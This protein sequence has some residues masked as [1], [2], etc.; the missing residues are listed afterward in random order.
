[1][2]IAIQAGRRLHFWLVCMACSIRHFSFALLILV[3]FETLSAN[4]TVYYL[5]SR[6]GSDDSNGTSPGTA[7]K[8]LARVNAQMFHAGDEIRFKAGTRYVGQLKPQGSG[9]IEDGKV[10]PIVIDAY[11]KGPRPRIDGEGEVLDTLLLRNV[12]FWD[13]RGLEITNLGKHR[14][15]W[16][17]GVH[18]V[19]D[20]F[21]TMW[22][23]HLQDLFVHDVNGDLRKEREGC[24]IFFES[25]GGNHSH[26]DNLLIENCHLL[27]TDRNG[28]CQRTT[29]RSRSLHVVIHGNLLEDIGGDGIKVWGSDGPLVEHNV[30]RGGRMRCKD[31]AAGIWPYD[32]DNAVIQ[33]NEVSGMKGTKDGEGFDS[34]YRCRHSLFQYNYS[35][36]NDGGFML[37]CTPGNSY[38][39]DTVIRYNISQNDGINTARVFHFGGGAKD[40][41][42]YNN[43]VYVGRKQDLPLLLFTEWNRGNASNTKFYN[44]IF[45]VDGHVTCDFG[46][47]TNNVFDRNVFYCPNGGIPPQAHAISNRPPLINPGSGGNGFASLNGYRLRDDAGFPLGRIVPN[48]GG[49][50]FFGNP[51]PQD[52]EP[53]I[54]AVQLVP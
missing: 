34:D 42:V 33:F 30:L 6:T 1:M 18:I 52:S 40:T 23:I 28:I 54:G 44:N 53:S 49:R 5:D 27:R 32:C 3:A 51:V 20:N 50:D 35:H 21:G 8:S 4:A 7:W 48:N 38:N 26:F 29:S 12:E 11:G 13:V 39:E 9:R 19:A 2:K 47:I 37:I 22:H 10:V 45:Y 31:Y 24:G 46:K 25:R 41:L 16:R 17:T 14:E 15:P 36:D 43:T